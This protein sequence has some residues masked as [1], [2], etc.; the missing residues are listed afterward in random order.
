MG[1]HVWG[2]FVG[3]LIPKGREAAVQASVE[4]AERSGEFTL[5]EAIGEVIGAPVVS[6]VVCEQG[7]PGMGSGCP[8]EPTGY[9][10]DGAPVY[11]RRV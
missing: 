5:T 11:G 2:L 4:R 3:L 6:C 8:G 10:P 9:A 1:E 7:W